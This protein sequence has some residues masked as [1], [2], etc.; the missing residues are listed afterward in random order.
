MTNDKL[1]RCPRNWQISPS[2]LTLVPQKTI[3]LKLVVLDDVPWTFH[4]DERMTIT[5]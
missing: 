5:V 4:F 2:L 3:T 1:C